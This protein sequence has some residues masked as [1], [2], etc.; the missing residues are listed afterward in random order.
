MGKEIAQSQ[1]GQGDFDRFY[2]S[3]RDETGLFSDLVA[4]KQLSEEGFVIGF[5]IEAWL[6]D[7]GFFP[8]RATSNF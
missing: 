5:E 3:L 6:L 1:F 2:E 7:H 8:S 4:G